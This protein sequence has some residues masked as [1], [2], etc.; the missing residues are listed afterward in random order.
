M[1][2]PLRVQ[3]PPG[4][5]WSYGGWE[6]RDLALVFS[7]TGATWEVAP[8]GWD[9]LNVVRGSHD[10]LPGRSVTFEYVSD[11]KPSFA[12]Y[13]AQ[14][15]SVDTSDAE[16]SLPIPYFNDCVAGEIVA[17][18]LQGWNGRQEADRRSRRPTSG[19][20]ASESAMVAFYTADSAMVRLAVCDA[21]GRSIRILFD[22]PLGSGFHSAKWDGSA[23]DKHRV[24]PGTYVYRLRVGTRDLD[25]TKPVVVRRRK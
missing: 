9:S 11:V 6:T 10:L 12:T 3:V 24:P 25:G 23:V 20:G 4:W 7:A 15:F 14:G 17:P 13:Y 5:V 1:P 2:R 21:S 8:F 16:R 18:G 22:G 19:I